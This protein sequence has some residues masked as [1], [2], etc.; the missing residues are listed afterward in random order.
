VILKHFRKDF[1]HLTL[2]AIRRTINPDEPQRNQVSH[3]HPEFHPLG[4]GFGGDLR[5]C[6]VS[7]LETGVKS[8]RSGCNSLKRPPL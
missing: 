6:P 2:S 4:P 8:L 1:A 5:R 3:A 7:L